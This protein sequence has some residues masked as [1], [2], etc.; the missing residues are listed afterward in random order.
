[1]AGSF[2]WIPPGEISIKVPYSDESKLVRMRRG[3]W[4]SKYLITQQLYEEV[5]GLNPSFLI[6]QLEVRSP[7]FR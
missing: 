7:I 4:M 3:Y 2:L 6:P 5:M 1:M